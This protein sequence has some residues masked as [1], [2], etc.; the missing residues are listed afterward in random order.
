MKILTK[1]GLTIDA[2]V[3]PDTCPMCKANWNAVREMLAN[4]GNRW[5]Y[6]TARTIIDNCPCCK[7]HLEGA[8]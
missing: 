6:L 1:N 5:D 3:M 4:R 2:P 8:K 7:A